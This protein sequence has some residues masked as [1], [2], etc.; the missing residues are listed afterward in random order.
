MSLNSK[1]KFF[2]VALLLSVS[3]TC[4]NQFAQAK[5][6]TTKAK[7]AAKTA[8]YYFADRFTFPENTKYFDYDSRPWR[9]E[10]KAKLSEYLSD[11]KKSA[12]GVV[13]LASAY[14]NIP[15]FRSPYI[16][17][18]NILGKTTTAYVLAVDGALFIGDGAD[19]Q[20]DYKRLLLHE[21]IHMA[22]IGRHVAYSPTWVA[23]AKPYL[24]A[25]RRQVSCQFLLDSKTEDFKESKWPSTESCTSY[26]ESLCEFGSK[27]VLEPNFKNDFRTFSNSVKPLFK[28]SKTDI[29]FSKHFMAGR[30]HFRNEKPDDAIKEFEIAATNDPAAPS[31]HVFLAQ[32]WYQ[33]K[34]MTKARDELKKAKVYFETAKV[35]M[36]E[37]LH[38]RTLSMLANADIALEDFKSAK[39]LL[40]RL[41]C[42]R[43]N[44]DTA[45]F[46]QRALCNQK[47]ENFRDA[48]LDIY[49]SAYLT[50]HANEPAH[51]FDF[52]ED[53]EFLQNFLSKEFKT[54]D[55]WRSHV[56]SLAWERLAQATDG[57]QRNEFVASARK[58]VS[59]ALSAGYYTKDEAEIRNGYLTYLDGKVSHETDAPVVAEAETKASLE[60]QSS[61]TEKPKTLAREF[62]LVKLLTGDPIAKKGTREFMR[63]VL[64]LR[65]TEGK[66]TKWLF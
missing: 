30:I 19:D 52:I 32:C 47:L 8:F 62:E 50:D 1:T 33:K 2:A 27:Y 48:L 24:Q 51:Y 38:W 55:G 14:G 65:P 34:D 11:L 15:I 16:P 35:G 60:T 49:H 20:K 64:R 23:S 54:A 29:S 40:D 36:T 22:D 41:A 46:I 31:P 18:K 4:S 56:F 26:K 12:P 13:A 10:E 37:S 42:S 5:D 53:R 21:L 3:A 44:Y 57:K 61:R 39:A 28:P 66:D 25:E 63:L 17:Y 45:I 6:K 43:I 7:K 9:D 59:N 58:E